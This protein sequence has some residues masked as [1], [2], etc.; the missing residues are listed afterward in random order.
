MKIL[1]DLSALLVVAAT[2]LAC[3]PV[4]AQQRTSDLPLI[5]V[6]ARDHAVLDLERA[7]WLCE[8]AATTGAVDASTGALCDVVTDELKAKKF[9]GDFGALLAWWHENKA[10][11]HR[12]LASLASLQRP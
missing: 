4:S 12:A 5:E 2:A 6:T 7:F 11:Q 3:S 9:G 1:H 8:H 10:V